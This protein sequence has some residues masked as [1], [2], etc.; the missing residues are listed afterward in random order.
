LDTGD[1]D[2]TKVSSPTLVLVIQMLGFC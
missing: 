1:F 2:Y